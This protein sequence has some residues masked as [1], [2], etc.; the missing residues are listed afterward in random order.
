VPDIS[1]SFD[2]NDNFKVATS[3][4]PAEFNGGQPGEFV[5]VKFS[6]KYNSSASLSVRQMVFDARYFIAIKASRVYSELSRREVQ[7]TEIE[8]VSSVSKAYYTAQVSQVNQ[9]LAEASIIRLQK[10]KKDT[11]VQYSAGLAEKVDVDRVQ[12]LLYNAETQ[13]QNAAALTELT[14]NQL[15]YQMGMKQTYELTLSDVLTF[16]TRPDFTEDLAKAFDYTQRIEYRVLQ[17][18]LEAGTIHQIE[19]ES[20][21]ADEWTFAQS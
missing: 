11:E 13:L 17:S 7:R 8:T 2:Y 18:N 6:P 20:W 9:Q 14:I 16:Q 12:V 19:P 21:V 1:A 10:Q 15:K 3:F 5:G 4:I